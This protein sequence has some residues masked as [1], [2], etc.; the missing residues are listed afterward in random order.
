[1]RCYTLSFQYFK[2]IYFFLFHWSFKSIILIRTTTYVIN[3]HVFIKNVKIY[4]IFLNSSAILYELSYY[5]Y[6]SYFLPMQ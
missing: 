1:M 3:L 5:N 4:I 6:G 2:Y